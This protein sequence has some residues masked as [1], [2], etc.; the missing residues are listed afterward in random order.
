MC[1]FGISASKQHVNVNH[2]S[3]FESGVYTYIAI[4]RGKKEDN[5]S[6]VGVAIFQTDK[7]MWTW[8]QD[9]PSPEDKTNDTRWYKVHLS[10]RHGRGLRRRAQHEVGVHWVPVSGGFRSDTGGTPESS[11]SLDQLNGPPSGPSI[12][13]HGKWGSPISRNSLNSNVT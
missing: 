9:V 2:M 6:N 5:S 7:A 10:L 4:L 11:Q 13:T 3:A 8:S 12:E 1:L